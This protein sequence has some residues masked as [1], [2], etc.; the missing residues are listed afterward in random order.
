[1]GGPRLAI[2]V[3]AAR[4]RADSGLKAHKDGTVTKLTATVGEVVASGAVICD[5]T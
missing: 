1:M 3:D 5:I 4:G 2:D